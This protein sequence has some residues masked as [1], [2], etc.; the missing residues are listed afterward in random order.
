MKT[1]DKY[2]KS[3]RRRVP[4]QIRRHGS[5]RQP[6]SYLDLHAATGQSFRAYLTG[7]RVEKA[8][9]MLSTGNSSIVEISQ[10]IGFC[11][12]SYFG[13]VFRDLVVI[14]LREFANMPSPRA[15]D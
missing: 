6:I 5:G 12:Q 10:Q 15:A 7:F 4:G 3:L 14:R 11:S 8:Q 1:K 9:A 13:E 2:K